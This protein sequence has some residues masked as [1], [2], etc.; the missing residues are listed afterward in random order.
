M[1]EH[2]NNVVSEWRQLLND[3]AAE[4]DEMRQNLPLPVDYDLIRLQCFVEYRDEYQIK[5]DT[6]T[7]EC[8][9]WRNLFN[10]VQRD[11]EEFKASL[12]NKEKTY[13]TFIEDLHS[14]HEEEKALLQ[15]KIKEKNEALGNLCSKVSYIC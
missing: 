6:L 4:F 1:E 2:H 11:H 9:N 13:Q 14:S 12:D 5:W 3:K 8:A 10:K 7:E 15:L